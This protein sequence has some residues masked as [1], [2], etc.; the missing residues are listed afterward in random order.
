MSLRLRIWNRNL[1]PTC[2]VVEESVTF[3]R[4]SSSD[5]LSLKI[6][7]GWTTGLTGFTGSGT[8]WPSL[9]SSVTTP[10]TPSRMLGHHEGLQQHQSQIAIFFLRFFFFFF[11]IFSLSPSDSQESCW[12]HY[13]AGSYS[14]QS[15]QEECPDVG[16]ATV[17]SDLTVYH[18]VFQLASHIDPSDGKIYRSEDLYI[19]I[20]ES[21]GDYIASPSGMK[22]VY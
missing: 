1:P 20:P 9:S 16:V 17:T 15:S 22:S 6:D 10:T 2:R 7:P 5:S 18:R 19:Y 14:A 12:S 3:R 8:L 13:T 11:I 21:N 4:R